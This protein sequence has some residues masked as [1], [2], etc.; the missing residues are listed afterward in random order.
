MEQTDRQTD[1]YD[2]G[3]SSTHRDTK[4]R[5]TAYEGQWDLFKTMPDIV[6]EWGWQQE[7]CPTTE[8]IHYQGYYRTK[9]QIRK[10]QAIK[11]FPGVNI[12]AIRNWDAYKNYCKKADTAVPGTQVHQVSTTKA[13]TMAA[14]L[15]KLATFADNN[16]PTDYDALDYDKRKEKYVKEEYWRAVRKIL[17]EEPDEVGLWTQPQYMRAW[18]NTRSIWIQ[19]AQETP[20]EPV[21]EADH[22]FGAEGSRPSREILD[23]KGKSEN[24]PL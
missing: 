6:A 20:N 24:I 11:I 10:S 9:R 7:V 3:V 2:S 14:A 16:P 23:S 8:R 13:M 5:F 18:E 17:L 22:S 1:N 21:G 15:T 12:D 19:K 4:W